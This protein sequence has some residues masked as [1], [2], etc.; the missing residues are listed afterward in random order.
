MDID[1][2][3]FRA[4]PVYA[5]ANGLR[6]DPRTG[7][8]RLGEIRRFARVQ[9][10]D[11]RGHNRNGDVAYQ[12]V[13]DVISGLLRPVIAARVR[14]AIRLNNV[15]I[16]RRAREQTL[17]I[18][19]FGNFPQIN[20]FSQEEWSRVLGPRATDS[21]TFFLEELARRGGDIIVDATYNTLM[22]AVRGGAD[23]EAVIVAT[24]S[25]VSLTRTTNRITIR[26]QGADT[27][28][29][30]LDEDGV[31]RLHRWETHSVNFTTTPEA[32]RERLLIMYKLFQ[33]FMY[34]QRTVLRT[35]IYVGGL[36]REA[37]GPGFIHQNLLRQHQFNRP[38]LISYNQNIG[39]C[40]ID[41]LYAW[42]RQN[43]DGTPHLKPRSRSNQYSRQEIIN[44]LM[45]PYP[46]THQWAA[47]GFTA[48]DLVRVG[49]QLHMPYVRAFGPDAIA[50]PHARPILEWVGKAQSHAG[51]G[52][53][54]GL[55]GLTFVVC[56][57]HVW[58]FIDDHKQ[59]MN[60]CVSHPFIPTAPGVMITK[61]LAE[62]LAA[63]E[64]IV[65]LD[66]V[67]SVHAH[68]MELASQGTVC[69]VLS[70]D[71]DTMLITGARI[72]EHDVY[73]VT[74]ARAAMLVLAK[75]NERHRGDKLEY[76]GESPQ[77]LVIAHM[78]KKVTLSIMNP[79]VYAEF[80]KTGDGL[81]CVY[82][83]VGWL[84]GC[85]HTPETQYYDM[86]RC[87]PAG[88]VEY[89]KPV[90]W[91]NITA[92]CEFIEYTGQFVALNAIYDV[93]APNTS[94]TR[95]CLVDGRGFY[96]GAVVREA[97]DDKL[98]TPQ[99][100]RRV[101]AQIRPQPKENE[102]GL[103]DLIRTLDELGPDAKQVSNS[104]IGAL[105]NVG[106]YTNKKRVF[107]AS[108]TEAG[109]LVM[110]WESQG[111]TAKIKFHSFSDKP[112]PPTGTMG[113]YIISIEEEC[114]AGRGIIGAI[115]YETTP[116]PVN[117]LIVHS[118]SIRMAMLLM[119]RH[120][121]Q[122]GGEVQGYMIDCVAINRPACPEH[123]EVKQEAR[124]GDIVGWEV[125]ESTPL[126]PTGTSPL[127]PTYKLAPT[128]PMKTQAVLRDAP[129]RTAPDLPSFP[130][131]GQ[132]PALIVG[133]AGYG[134]SY[135][136]ANIA[137]E[138]V[139]A[140]QTVLMLGPT[141]QVREN[142]EDET[143]IAAYVPEA[144]ENDG[145]PE[146]YDADVS[147]GMD[148]PKKG[149]LTIAT[150]H[151][152]LGRYQRGDENK[153]KRAPLWHKNV[154]VVIIDEVFACSHGMLAIAWGRAKKY[155]TRLL[156]AGDDAQL[157]PVE[158][159]VKLSPT[160]PLI[161][162]LSN[163]NTI[164]LHENRR[165]KSDDPDVAGLA[166]ILER[167]R[168]GDTTNLRKVFP[169]TA[170]D[171][172]IVFTNNKMDEVNAEKIDAK[173]PQ[174]Y[175]KTLGVDA[176]PGM[177]VRCLFNCG[178]FT[179]G[180]RW[181]ITATTPEG[182]TVERQGRRPHTETIPNA[183]YTATNW[184]PGYAITAHSAQGMTFNQPYTIHEW[185]GRSADW[186]YVA[187]TRATRKSFISLA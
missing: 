1:A 48:E 67:Q 113:D 135:A 140:N 85:T 161:R 177:P 53:G 7:E 150:L 130:Q 187:L 98:I 58:H 21:A 54:H 131:A 22:S 95:S 145:V 57:G 162:H 123:A 84:A 109:G 72:G 112:R 127:H 70:V 96:P 62:G 175:V 11:L 168:R 124:M 29:E 61:D 174:G 164:R 134:K 63:P 76:H 17:V 186:L 89:S 146:G 26:E 27:Y 180:S 159:G 10:I 157:P 148:Q 38:G 4:A 9:G 149:S 73:E 183:K 185:R 42:T 81:S 137:V 147:G 104:M 24:R 93:D 111:I 16:V 152:A 5:Q 151:R 155:G 171:L 108:W 166:A 128:R 14:E 60:L 92:D 30:E 77:R 110:L 37:P 125:V 86:K 181:I 101:L 31:V 83:P 102:D 88:A 87:Y 116:Q 20:I 139:K 64:G 44:M 75:I 51:H 18:P 173:K 59:H 144:T 158:D 179:N 8:A 55:R 80:Q 156:I 107:T 172:N 49:K 41:T 2:L 121:K 71:R 33:A 12:R 52:K 106:T 136:I 143:T 74:S 34:V 105:K 115:G 35:P 119:W 170:S 176:F 46:Q 114:A 69:P 3:A 78:M 141:H 153:P 117:N 163:N 56:D 36:P 129:K 68:F 40:T 120:V 90:N 23:R 182:V 91:C 82:P 142:L 100:I 184:I 178:H 138:L 15:E 103:G 118:M 6:F 28:V 94:D 167:V 65:Y 154:D 66:G 126:I 160:S 50:D 165:L 99:Q 32:M 169:N 45:E 19:Q 97:L 79:D 133:G 25:Y 122:L 13:I 43:A 132:L 39:Q 47:Q